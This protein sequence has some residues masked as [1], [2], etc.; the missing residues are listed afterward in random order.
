MGRV[1]RDCPEEAKLLD[2]SS[3]EQLIYSAAGVAGTIIVLLLAKFFGGK[4]GRTVS[5]IETEK[6]AVAIENASKLISER[7]VVE[8]KTKEDKKRVQ[9]KLDIEDPVERLQALADELRSL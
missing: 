7:V 5:A 1:V 9:E 6:T 3:M 2:G 8:A 4:R